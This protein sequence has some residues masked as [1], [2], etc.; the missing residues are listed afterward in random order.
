VEPEKTSIASQWH[1]KRVLVAMNTHATI[2]EPW[3]AVFYMRSVPRLYNEDQG[4]KLVSYESEVIVS[5]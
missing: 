1:G 4:D 2:E 3:E 5:G